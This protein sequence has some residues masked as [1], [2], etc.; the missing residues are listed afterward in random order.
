L[1]QIFPS[2]PCS[3]TQSGYIP[4]SMSESKVHTHTKLQE[5]YSLY[6][7]ISTFLDSRREDKRFWTECQQALPELNLLISSWIKFWFVTVVPKYLNCATFSKEFVSSLYVTILA[8]ILVTKQQHILS[9]L[10]VQYHN[11]KSPSLAP[12]SHQF[13][14]FDYRHDNG[15][16]QSALLS[17]DNVTL[18][19]FIFSTFIF[20]PPFR[21]I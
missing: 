17:V 2:A 16:L 4:N 18:H 21:G 14:R 20:L 5:K 12:T 1:V 7:L 6:V 13:S 9:F 19:L 3:Q 8:C 15:I 10:C 11:H